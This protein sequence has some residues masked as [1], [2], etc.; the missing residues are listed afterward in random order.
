[1]SPFLPCAGMVGGGP[2][3]S[4]PGYQQDRVNLIKET[5]WKKT[6]LVDVESHAVKVLKIDICHY[7]INGKKNSC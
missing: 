3:G 5:V 6:I 7:K 2:A 1:M 4:V